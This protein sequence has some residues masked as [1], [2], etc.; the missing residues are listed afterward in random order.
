MDLLT[1]TKGVLQKYG[2]RPN[3]RLGQNFIIDESI[4]SKQ[5]EYASLR[6]SEVVVEVGAGIGTL[7]KFLLEKAGKV[8]VIE[9]DKK[10][11]GVLKDRFSGI[12]NLEI[13]S[14]DVLRVELPEFDKMVSNIPYVISSPLTF[15]LLKCR[16]KKAII[17]YQREFAERM[18]ARPGTKDY[19][20]L[21]VACYYYAGIRLLQIVPPT[22]FYPE[23]EVHSAIIEITPKEPPFDVDEEF[24]FKVLTGLFVHRKKTV[25]NALIHSLDMIFDERAYEKRRSMIDVLP[26]EIL[27]RRVFRLTPREI[28]D[29]SNTLEGTK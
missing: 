1:E 7:T 28:A 26:P 19:S 14:G 9:R 6:S 18:V 17:T 23:P 25:K 15:K 29:I 20:R 21:S 2:I 10:M 13:I 27:E 3:Q 12:E 11:I 4:I 5:I 24:F 16:F 22:A 8:Y